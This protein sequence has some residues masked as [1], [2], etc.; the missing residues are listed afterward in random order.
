MHDTVQT[1]VV[2]EPKLRK[3]TPFKSTH[4]KDDILCESLSEE[5]KSVMFPFRAAGEYKDAVRFRR[6]LSNIKIGV[7]QLRNSASEIEHFSPRPI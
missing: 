7:D 6:S 4:A 3:A 1:S 5:V 2:S